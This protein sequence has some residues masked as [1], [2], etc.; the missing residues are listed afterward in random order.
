MGR[1]GGY[2]PKFV[3]NVLGGAP[4]ILKKKKIKR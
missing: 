1:V 2:W 4:V 3:Q